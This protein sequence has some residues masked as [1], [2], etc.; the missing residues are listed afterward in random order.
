[1]KYQCKNYYHKGIKF[2]FRLSFSGN[3][4][5]KFGPQNLEEN[6]SSKFKPMVHAIHRNS[7]KK[8]T[9]LNA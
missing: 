9:I 7:F 1:M 6:E 3:R 8:K 2:S 5:F 4:D